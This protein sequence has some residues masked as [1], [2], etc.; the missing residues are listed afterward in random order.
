MAC[1]TGDACGL[2]ETRSTDRSSVNHRAVMIEAIDALDAWCPP[3]LTPEA[4]ATD[5]VGVVDHRG[6][7]PA[8]PLLDEARGDSRCTPGAPD[9]AATGRRAFDRSG[10]VI[11]QADQIATNCTIDRRSAEQYAQVP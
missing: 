3:T 1:S 11:T 2:T 5:P 6:G 9:V 10:S 4:V 8:H 7:E